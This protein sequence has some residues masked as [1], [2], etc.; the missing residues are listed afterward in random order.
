MEAASV[1]DRDGNII[2]S[3]VTFTAKFL[4][5]Y[6]EQNLHQQVCWKSENGRL[7]MPRVRS[8]QAYG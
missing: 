1:I 8:S 3:P 4:R 5:L 7:T 6:N 2:L